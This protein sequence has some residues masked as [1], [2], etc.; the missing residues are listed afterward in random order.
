MVLHRPVET[1]HIFSKFA[2]PEM[3]LSETPFSFML[4]DPLRDG[5]T[6]YKK[7]PL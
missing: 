6:H 7:V 1:A 3:K 5:V 2:A 4:A